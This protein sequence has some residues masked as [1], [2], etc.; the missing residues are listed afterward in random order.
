[1]LRRLQ[2]FLVL[3]MCLVS[4][5]AAAQDATDKP[6]ADEPAD[7]PPEKAPPAGKARPKPKAASDQPADAEQAAPPKD[8]PTDAVPPPPPPAAPA[9][10]AWQ[11]GWET[12][13]TGYFRAPL[14]LG[15]SN[16]ARPDQPKTDPPTTQI[17]YGPNR[18][19]D[20]SYYSFAYTRLQEQ[21]WAE[22]FI[23]EKH[24][25]V[26]AVIGWMGYWYQAVGFQ[27]PDAAW[28][29]G[30]AYLALDTDVP[31]GQYKPNVALTMGAFWP[32]YGYFE[33]Y[34]TYTLGRFRQMGVQLK[35]TWP[36][37]T[38]WTLTYTQ[39][40]GAGRDGSFALL[41]PPPYQAT[42]GL[43]LL[44]YE[45][46]QFQWGKYVDF[47]GHVN[48]E[49]TAD[50][51]LTQQ[52][53]PDPKSYGP[54][55][56]ANLS[57]AGF[58]VNFNIPYAGRIW[59]SPSVIKVTN[60][61][62]L[63]NAGTEVMHSLGGVGIATNYMAWSGSPSDSTGSG[64]MNNFGVLFETSMNRWLNRP[65]ETTP[66]LTLSAFGLVTNS[67]IDLPVGSTI[68]Q[69]TIKEAKG[70]VDATFQPWPFLAAMLRYDSVNLD[71]DHPAYIFSGVTGRLVFSS[72]FMSGESIYFQYTRY[73][74]G[75]HMVL[76]GTWPW[77]TQLVAGNDIIQHGP[78]AGQK[79]DMDVIKIQANVA[80]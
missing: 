46:F 4:I 56:Q 19:L 38:N 32:K 16:R 29:P 60:G 22:L 36:I 66:E 62:A 47:S 21:D 24:K 61:W 49:W 55:T 77:G 31:L 57:V 39:G 72:H 20:A 17:S 41:A 30:T 68:P 76:A 74:Y 53:M 15:I 67:S 27:N 9:K 69:N 75:D 78:Y 26:E 35:V 23:H 3:G 71:T 44:T 10:P 59:I 50:P 2:A 25:H 42:V 58:E 65:A 12:F 73:T 18:T 51:N 34:D 6:A 80:F 48:N 33:K 40:F 7:K 11:E 54:A 37:S 63:A 8:Q 13:A 79:P 45:N 70:G 43:D 14:A 28:I 52:T 1:M 64:T 5:P